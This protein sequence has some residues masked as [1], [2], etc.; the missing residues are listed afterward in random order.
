MKAP[1]PPPD[2]PPLALAAVPP[3]TQ[4][5]KK[6][7]SV[8]RRWPDVEAEIARVTTLEPRQWAGLTLRSETLVHLIRLLRQAGETEVV[9]KLLMEL[10]DR[11]V[12]TAKRW[13]RGFNKDV[14]EEIAEEVGLAIIG[15]VFAQEPSRQSEYL[16]C[17]FDEAVQRRAINLNQSKRVKCLRRSRQ[18]P[19]AATEEGDAVTPGDQA[20]ADDGPSPEDLTAEA[21]L[22]AMA[23]GQ[24]ERALA[25]ISNPDHRKAVVLR[26]IDGWPVTD[27]Q[28]PNRPT[29]TKYFGVC[30][31]TIRYWMRA[32]FSEMRHALGVN[33]EQ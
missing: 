28:D 7:G 33:H 11:T 6:D 26:Y 13:A 12:A 21:E 10:S 8:Y 9:G 14:T 31:G 5:S 15:L 27:Q 32:A 1:D 2:P 4:P 16:E 3:L 20:V 25:A 30:D 18:F 29:I 17:A 22:R 23:P 24:I 19:E